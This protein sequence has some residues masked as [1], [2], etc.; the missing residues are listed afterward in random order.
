MK[1]HIKPNK[2]SFRVGTL[3]W[4][5]F[6]GLPIALIANGLI[7]GYFYLQN[8]DSFKASDI[9]TVSIFTLSLGV[10]TYILQLKRLK[11]KTFNLTKELDE[12]RELTRKILKENDWRI[13]NDNQKFIV[14]SSKGKMFSSDMII[15][16]FKKKKIQWN[17]IQ[18]PWSHN[19][20]AALLNLNLKGKKILKKIKASA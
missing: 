5:T 2:I 4:L 6:F 13:E 11:Y 10:I 8:V 12:F 7:S 15:L 18:H 9:L 3:E 19:S 1:E 17:L 16:R 14:A 20:G